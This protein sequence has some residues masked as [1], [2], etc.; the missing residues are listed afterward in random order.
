MRVYRR[1]SQ[2]RE[3]DNTHMP[4][5]KISFLTLTECNSRN[6]LSEIITNNLEKLLIKIYHFH[7]DF[8]LQILSYCLCI[9]NQTLSLSYNFY[10]ISKRALLCY[11]IYCILMYIHIQLP[12]IYSKI[13]NFI[14]SSNYKLDISLPL[15]Y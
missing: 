2:W 12:G 10:V 9:L 11:S 15:Q 8:S 1:W 6:F 5:L 7:R 4:F 3:L 13:L 14:L